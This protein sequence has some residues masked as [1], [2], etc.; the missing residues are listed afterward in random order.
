MIEVQFA[1]TR[2]FIKGFQISGHAGYAKYGHDIV[3]AAA[4]FLAI[5]VVNSLELQ[6]GCAGIVKGGEDGYLYYRLP[7]ELNREQQEI[8][9]II[10]QTLKVGFENLREEY[11]EYVSIKNLRIEGGASK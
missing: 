9:Q 11:P 8:A 7:E 10:L 6:L 3:C 5:T 1:K 2:D 4:S